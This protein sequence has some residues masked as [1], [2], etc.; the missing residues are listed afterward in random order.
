MTAP[1][2]YLSNALAAQHE[3]IRVIPNGI[4][5]SRYTH[6]TRVQPRPSLVWLRALH[7]IYN[8]L[9]AVQVVARLR[10]RFPDITLRM[11]GPAKDG[12]QH[13]VRAEID[14]LGLAHIV[15]L[16]G[17]IPK[18]AVPAA[19]DAA[20][21]FINTTNVDN[22]PVSVIEAMAAGLCVVSTDAGGLRDLLTDEVDALLVPIGDVEAMAAAVARILG[23][24]SVAERISRNGD[25]VAERSAWPEVMAAWTAL[26]D[27]VTQRAAA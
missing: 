21:I 11:I 26:L 17:A 5:T 25:V 12:S 1:S 6:R 14:A 4:D 15:T 2:T 10:D 24:T 22:T 16:E 27:D 19:L 18:D 20:D 8:P 7:T 13:A 23:D 9:M 3:P